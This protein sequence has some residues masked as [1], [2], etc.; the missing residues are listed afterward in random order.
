M[1][2][3]GGEGARPGARVS[4]AIVHDWMIQMRGGEK[5]LE[6]I[7]R[8]YP[9]APIFT[10][11]CDRSKLSPELA[12]R[13]I[14]TSLLNR[15]PAIKQLYRW[16]LPIFPW[17]I[18]QF[19]LSGFEMVISSSHCVAKG[20]RVPLGAR[21]VCYCH[22]PMRYAWGFEEEYLGNFPGPVR[23]LAR[24]ILA[25]LRAWDQATNER[26]D[27]FLCNSEHVRE[28]IR[29][30]YGREATVV[31]P[32]CDVD[33]LGEAA[34]PRKDFYLAVS[35][36]VPYKRVDL[37]VQAFTEAG[38]PL[39]VV[40]TG[41]LRSRLQAMAGPSVKFAGW[42][43]DGT[44]KRLYAQARALVF[45]GV[46]DFG[47][48]PVEAQAQGC[49][50]IA[51]AQGGV[52]ESVREYDPRGGRGS[53]VFFREQSVDALLQAVEAARRIVWDPRAIRE[54]VKRFSRET[55]RRGLEERI[56]GRAPGFEPDIQWAGVSHAT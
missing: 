1:S 55:F 21:H 14:F 26:V 5:V 29:R 8:L 25:R 10:L 23:R 20:V 31:Y 41:P 3:K 47:I 45:P 46:E 27:F 35:H 6:E 30:F 7:S 43:D 28:R 32:P 39:V 24:K 2:S 33:A 36:L 13:V 44:L 53:G 54:G 50:V 37:A 48:V 40:G 38:L 19:D 56:Q 17:M 4:V 16:L 11:F 18:R 9:N 51:F 49:P 42:V 15:L 52:L 12:G 22:T 34:G